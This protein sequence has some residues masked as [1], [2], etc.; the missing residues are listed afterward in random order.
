MAELNSAP[1]KQGKKVRSNKKNLRVDLTAMVDLAFLLITF[2]MLTTTLTK[3]R[4]MDLNMPVGDEP[5]PQVASRTLT[6]CLGKNNQAMY[7]LGLADK[8]LLP[9]TITNYGKSGLRYAI[10]EVQKKVLAATGKGLMVIIKPA[11]SSVYENLVNTLDEMT[12]TGV[13]QFAIADIDAKDISVL[14]EKQAY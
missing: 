14:K 8:P 6:I 7:Y 9:A 11:D 3:P 5:G 12:I 10:M 1:E 4:A 2:F 13:P